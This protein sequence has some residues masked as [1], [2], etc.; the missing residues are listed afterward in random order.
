MR[1]RPELYPDAT[2]PLLQSTNK[3]A[4]SYEALD[5]A[6]AHPETLSTATD[7]S[8]YAVSEYERVMYYHAEGGPVLLYRSDLHTRPYPLPPAPPPPRCSTL[9]GALG[10]A[11]R[12]ARNEMLELEMLT[13]I[14]DKWGITVFN[15]S[16]MF[17]EEGSGDGAGEAG[18]GAA[19]GEPPVAKS[20][21]FV[22][23]HVHPGGVTD[24][25]AAHDASEEILDLFE[26]HGVP[27]GRLT[28]E[29]GEQYVRMW[30]SHTNYIDIRD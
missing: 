11:L 21:P 10:P 20:R 19:D 26:K 6:R 3:Q 4:L 12:A 5:A 30:G 29:W 23:V 9:S 27:R 16:I 22:M 25:Q 1:E 13:R 8:P 18:E 28:V 2:L 7:G 15:A 24:P 17:Y 14:R